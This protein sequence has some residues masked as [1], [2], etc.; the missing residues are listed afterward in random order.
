MGYQHNGQVEL[1]LNAAKLLLQTCSRNRV[2]SAERL[3]HKQ[4]I[5]TRRKRTRDADTLL[6]STR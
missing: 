1:L 5:G 2:E 6:L 4:H 3:I